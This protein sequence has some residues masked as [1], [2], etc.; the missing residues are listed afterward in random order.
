MFAGIVEETAKVIELEQG[1][2]ICRLTVASSLDHGETRIGDSVCVEGACLTVVAV[3]DSRVTFEL[4]HETL[5]RTTLGDLTVGT[6]V[7]L[8]R[9]LCLGGRIHGHL[10]AGHVD[11]VIRLR[12]LISEGASIKLEWELPLDLRSFVAP[13]GSVTIAGVSLTVGAVAHDHFTVY[14][15]PHTLAV[16]TLSNCRKGTRANLEVDLLARYVYSVLNERSDEEKP[17]GITTAFL[18]MHGFGEGKDDGR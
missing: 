3:Y 13:K 14:V 4:S 1:S 10:V 15:V 2:D 5:R 9:S 8:E 11:A 6:Q 12:S 7:N 17:S 18:N 16:T